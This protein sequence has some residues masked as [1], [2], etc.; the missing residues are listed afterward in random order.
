MLQSTF[1]PGLT[2]TGFRTTRPCCTAQLVLVVNYGK[3]FPPALPLE[4][5]LVVLL[6]FIKQGSLLR[7]SGQR[8]PKLVDV[9]A[10]RSSTCCFAFCS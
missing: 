10:F 9:V 6:Q 5:G 3:F 1:N 8:L 7:V 4:T 2:L